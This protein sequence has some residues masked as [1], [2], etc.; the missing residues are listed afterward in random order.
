[1]VDINSAIAHNIIVYLKNNHITR[2]EF[3]EGIGVTEPIANQILN[4]SKMPSAAEI[5]RIADYLHIST[6]ELLLMPKDA[7]E[8]NPVYALMEQVHSDAARQALA[9]ADELADMIIF[10]ARVR[11]N[12][13]AMMQTWEI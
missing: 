4:G 7:H 9:V 12:A 8:S 10:H 1:M 5:H 6:Q 2:T 11:E 3:A 13:E